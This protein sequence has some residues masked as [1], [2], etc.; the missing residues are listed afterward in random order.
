VPR[1]PIGTCHVTNGF[2]GVWSHSWPIP[3]L[4]LS[5][6]SPLF[7]STPS[8]AQNLPFLFF[9]PPASHRLL[10][11]HS[12][13]SPAPLSISDDD[14]VYIFTPSYLLKILYFKCFLEYVFFF[15]FWNVCCNIWHFFAFWFLSFCILGVEETMIDGLLKWGLW[16][17]CLVV[18]WV[19]LF[20]ITIFS[21]PNIRHILF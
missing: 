9:L 6:L 11:R 13:I 14:Q 20:I 21:R 16:L 19:Y 2:F 10:L 8:R 12:L 7:P 18:W 5:P 17:I 15:F 1:Y 4:L 3:L